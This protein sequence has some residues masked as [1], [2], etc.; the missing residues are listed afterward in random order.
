[1][2][3]CLLYSSFF[4]AI[5]N[6]TTIV[7]LPGMFGTVYAASQ[8]VWLSMHRVAHVAAGVALRHGEVAE[9]SA[10][11]MSAAVTA[12][13]IPCPSQKSAGCVWFT[14]SVAHFWLNVSIPYYF[15]VVRLALLSS[16]W[17]KLVIVGV[18]E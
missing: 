13:S 4:C 10:M 3:V 18:R 6:A 8:A 9:L 11:G 15:V 14:L 7:Q 12:R 5:Y 16:G 2:R 17:R 1:M